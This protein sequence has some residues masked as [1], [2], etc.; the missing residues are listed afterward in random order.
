M[1]IPFSVCS[2]TLEGILVF[3]SQPRWGDPQAASPMLMD[4]LM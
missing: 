1:Q 3:K 2:H 4:Y